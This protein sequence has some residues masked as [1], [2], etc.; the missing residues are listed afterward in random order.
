MRKHPIFHREEA[1]AAAARSNR[2]EVLFLYMFFASHPV[3]PPKVI[4]IWPN[5][6]RR[7]EAQLRQW[8]S[9]KGESYCRGTSWLLNRHRILNIYE[10][11]DLRFVLSE[12]NYLLF[13]FSIL[14]FIFIWFSRTVLTSMSPAA[15]A[16][17]VTQLLLQTWKITRL[18]KANLFP[19]RHISLSFCKRLLKVPINSTCILEDIML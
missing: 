4:G 6:G 19:A 15:L 1:S 2:M 8:K 10:A 5:E 12:T 14:F 7:N 11:T 9:L 18:R 16:S 13:S 17:S 3:L